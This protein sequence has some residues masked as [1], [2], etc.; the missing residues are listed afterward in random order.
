[1][2]FKDGHLLNMSLGKTCPPTQQPNTPS[3]SQS[4]PIH[5]NPSQSIPVPFPLEIKSG[6]PDVNPSLGCPLL[7]GTWGTL[8]AVSAVKNVPKPLHS[9]CFHS[10]FYWIGPQNPAFT[11]LDP[12]CKGKKHSRDGWVEFQPAHCIPDFLGII[13]RHKECLQLLDQS[14]VTNDGSTWE[15]EPG[16]SLLSLLIQ[17]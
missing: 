1:M 6:F 12:R 5:S 13:L 17:F 4:I 7:R 15:N 3:P 14:W 8:G 2:I 16:L 11:V 9:H 10:S